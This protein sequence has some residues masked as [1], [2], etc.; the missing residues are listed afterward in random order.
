M[1]RVRELHVVVPVHDEEELL[2]DCLA[3]IEAAVAA[4]RSR[5]DA[6]SVDVTVVLDACTDG[7]ADVVR[8]L[9]ARSVAV[10]VRSVGGARAAGVADVARRAAGPAGST[11]VATTDA[12]SRVPPSWLT[13]QLDLARDGVEL[14]IG[15]VRPERSDLSHE[16][17]SRWWRHHRRPAGPSIH[18]ANLGFTLAAYQ[19]AGG[20]AAVEE[21]ED[22]MFV[23]AAL[24]AGSRWVQSGPWVRTSG[25]THG[26]VVHGFSGYLRALVTE[27]G[28]S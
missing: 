7:S 22:V 24:R 18:G 11:W 20:F 1:R 28:C 15:R 19:R 9:A 27:S 14:F 5:P 21:H 3:A 26:R 13:A 4:V 10:E 25:R 12:D 16:V 2:P 23:E 6:P 8:R 17:M